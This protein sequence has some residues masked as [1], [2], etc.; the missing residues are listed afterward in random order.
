MEIQYKGIITQ[1]L[2]L[3]NKEMKKGMK[4]AT[5]KFVVEYSEVHSTLMTCCQYLCT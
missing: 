3:G 1:N 5:R 2:I 4:K